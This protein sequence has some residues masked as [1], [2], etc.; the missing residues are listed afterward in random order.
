LKDLRKENYEQILDKIQI[1]MPIKGAR[2]LEVGSAWGGFLEAAGKRGA[3][4]QGI[5]P[6]TAN[7]EKSLADSLAVE[8][9]YFPR[10]LEDSGPYSIIIFNDVFEHIPCPDSLCREIEARLEKG[11]LLVINLPSSN[12]AIFHIAS[13]LDKIG[14]SSPY[15]RLW[16]KDF[17]SPHVSYFSPENL[18]KMIELKTKLRQELMFSLPSVLRKGLYA[19]V[20]SSH[21]GI[22]GLMIFL[23]AWSLSFVLPM[24]RPDIVVCIF[25]SPNSTF[26]NR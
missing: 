12:G 5:E 6:E 26:N 19:R 22:F 20:K 17:T 7:V 2:L 11:G 18:K 1:L 13:M 16:Q 23:A 24:L 14:I 8:Q 9:G 25:R 10:D 15:E 21:T 4:A 3:L